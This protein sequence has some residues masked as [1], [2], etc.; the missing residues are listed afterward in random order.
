MR[1]QVGG[2]ALPL[3]LL[4]AERRRHVWP[5]RAGSARHHQQAL[6][7]LP[8]RDLQPPYFPPCRRQ[9]K[10][11]ECGYESN[12][13]DPCIDLSLEITRAQSVKRALE[14]F[15]QGESCALWLC[16]CVCVCV[17]FWGGVLAAHCAPQLQLG[18]LLGLPPRGAS[19]SSG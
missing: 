7:A 14:R 13:Y 18:F 6:C 8:A 12:T 17:W 9:V 2:A 15:T 1:S 4:R 19:F 10:C 16:V 3:R 11:C 5:L